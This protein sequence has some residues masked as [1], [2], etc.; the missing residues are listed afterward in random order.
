MRADQ[1]L[2]IASALFLADPSLPMDMFKE[3]SDFHSKPKSIIS[4][5]KKADKER[6]KKKAKSKLKKRNKR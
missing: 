4:A 6:R 3:K 5:K 1:V 2:G